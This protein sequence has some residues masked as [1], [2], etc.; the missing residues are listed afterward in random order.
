MAA[1]TSMTVDLVPVERQHELAPLFGTDDPGEILDRTAGIA[2]HHAKVV[3]QQRLSVRISGRDHVLVEGWTTLGAL[4]GV[5]P[6]TAWTR[7]LPDGDGWEAR[8]EARTLDGRVVGAAEAMCSRQ[9]KTWKTR[10]EFALRS[11]AATRATS[12][13]LR[14][15]LGFI[16]SLAGFAATPAEEMPDEREPVTKSQVAHLAQLVRDL[17]ELDDSTNWIEACK[18]ETGGR[19]ATDLTKAE[20]DGLIEKLEQA[21]TQLLRDVAARA[22]RPPT[23]GGDHPPTG[24]AEDLGDPAGQAEKQETL[25]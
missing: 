19:S 6:V 25:A 8:V 16:V 9:E 1:E 15:P 18:T 24:P 17:R 14:G 7:P 20:A 2:T 13:A 3:K 10:D 23:T 12:K 11:M 22:A 4:V 21:K 5:F